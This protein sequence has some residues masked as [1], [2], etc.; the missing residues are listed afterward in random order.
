MDCS[1]VG[2]IQDYNTI[3]ARS[4]GGGGEGG[5]GGGGGQE[6]FS[7]HAKALAQIGTRPPIY[8]CSL[9]YF[10]VKNSPWSFYFGFCDWQI[11][12]CYKI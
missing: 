9:V 2:F 7:I 11:V 12:L 4:G 10:R 8:Y 3:P 1:L 6:P 5:G